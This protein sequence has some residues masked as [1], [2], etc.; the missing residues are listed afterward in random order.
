MVSLFFIRVI[1]SQHQRGAANGISMTW[2]SLFKAFGPF[3]GG[4]LFSW[5]QSRKNASFLPG[6]EMVFFVLN[7]VEVVGLLMTF[8]PFLALP[9]QRG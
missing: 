6:S 8:K 3:G 1:L 9:Q 7:M 5:G 4:A 2:M